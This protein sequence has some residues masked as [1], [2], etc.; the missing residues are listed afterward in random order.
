MR[1]GERDEV[2]GAEDRL[3]P[4]DCIYLGL[5]IFLVNIAIIVLVSS[6]DAKFV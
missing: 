4:R 5:V 3:Q 6:V 1:R 2:V